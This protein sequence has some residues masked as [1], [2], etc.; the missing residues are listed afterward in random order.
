MR[1]PKKKIISHMYIRYANA[2][3]A[4]QLVRQVLACTFMSR[5][6]CF[7][8]FF[9]PARLQMISAILTRHVEVVVAGIEHDLSNSLTECA[10][11][12]SWRKEG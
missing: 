2:R 4:S 1:R 6:G 11:G 3:L 7:R 12:K 9:Q 8:Q 10:R 5:S